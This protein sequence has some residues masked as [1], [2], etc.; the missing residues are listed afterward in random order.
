MCVRVRVLGMCVLEQTAKLKSANFTAFWPNPPNIIPAKF[1][2]YTVII[3]CNFARTGVVIHGVV[4]QGL[5]V[6]GLVVTTDLLQCR[7]LP[8]QS[9]ERMWMKK[10]E[11][12]L[13]CE[14]DFVQIQVQPST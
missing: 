2:G 9:Q 10:R 3:Q 12:E 14:Y 8:T 1:Y 11:F 7:T 13:I 6:R 4:V 5:V